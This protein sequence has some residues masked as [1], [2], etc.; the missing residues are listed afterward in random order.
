MLEAVLVL[1]RLLVLLVA[2]FTAAPAL[3]LTPAAET[4]SGRI[5]AS[6]DGEHTYFAGEFGVWVH[7]GTC[8]EDIAKHAIGNKRFQGKTLGE[9][10]AHLEAMAGSTLG[11]KTADGASVWRRGSEVLIQRE[12]G[13]G[14]GTY[15]V[16]DSEK[17]AARYVSAMVEREGGVVGL[18]YPK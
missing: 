9:V 5:S 11:Q 15:F 7:N 2:A 12:A 14:V 16:A 17:A 4:A 6:L 10:T 1:A 8:F 13:N 3:A 18:I